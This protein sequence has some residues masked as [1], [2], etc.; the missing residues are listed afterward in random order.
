MEKKPVVS[1]QLAH[2]LGLESRSCRK[3]DGTSL[4]HLSPGHNQPLFGVVLVAQGELEGIKQSHAESSCWPA[5][6]S[7]SAMAWR[8]GKVPRTV[9]LAE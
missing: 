4:A 6:L 3:G 5:W 8:A 1:A 7:G 9:K 2:H